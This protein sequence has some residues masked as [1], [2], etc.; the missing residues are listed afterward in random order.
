MRTVAK[1][2]KEQRRKRAWMLTDRALV[3]GLTKAHEAEKQAE[4]EAFQAF[5]ADL[6]CVAL[7]ASE[8]TIETLKNLHS[9][10]LPLA[11]SRR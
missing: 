3:S 9:R 2:T 7:K 8:L 11:Y 4:E 10:F 1:L 5:C 6:D